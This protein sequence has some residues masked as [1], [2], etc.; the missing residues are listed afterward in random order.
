MSIT[1]H[2]YRWIAIFIAVL[3]ILLALAAFGYFTGNWD[4][5]ESARPGYGLASAESRP[6]LCMDNETRER[7][8]KL[9]LEALDEAFKEKIKD[10]YDVWLRDA[11]GQPARAAKGAEAALRAYQHARNSAMQFNP[12]ECSG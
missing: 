2:H 5:N 9:M 7:V 8:R 10:L 11:T 3:V 1:A 4:E 12:P 6:E